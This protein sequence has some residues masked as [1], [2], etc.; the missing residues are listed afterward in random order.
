M[1]LLNYLWALYNWAMV[2]EEPV[3]FFVPD[4]DNSENA[5]EFLRQR[6]NAP[7]SERRVYSLRFN[8][9]GD[10][11]TATVG[12]PLSVRH[13]IARRSKRW[14]QWGENFDPPRFDAKVIAI[15][16]AEPYLVWL[17]PDGRTQ[18]AN[19]FMVGQNSIQSVVH[20]EG[21]EE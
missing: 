1:R 7:S 9:D 17:H 8:H 10:Q 20:F 3:P 12:Q 18:W 21:D 4:V 5:W 19:P 11:V 13:P 14:S 15:F 16:E 2:T 6:C